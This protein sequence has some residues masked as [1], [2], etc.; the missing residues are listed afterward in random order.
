MTIE[1]TKAAR[2]AG[3]ALAA[4]AVWFGGVAAAAALF[5]ASSVVVFGPYAMEAA[6]TAGATL[7]DARTGLVRAGAEEPG[8][9]RR[10]YASGAWLVWPA[11]AGGCRARPR[12]PGLT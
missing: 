8:L 9:V 11:A 6:L 7:V 2:F 4:L 5:D 10:L 1:R 12:A 3:A